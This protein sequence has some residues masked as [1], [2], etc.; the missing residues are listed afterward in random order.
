MM[1]RI[2]VFRSLCCARPSRVSLVVVSADVLHA[3]IARAPSLVRSASGLSQ[4]AHH[5]V[6]CRISG[7]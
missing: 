4:Y 5:K 1:C 6:D 7:I 3:S 2:C